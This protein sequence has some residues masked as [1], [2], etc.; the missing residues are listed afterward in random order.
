MCKSVEFLIKILRIVIL[1]NQNFHHLSCLL[2]LSLYFRYIAKAQKT[3]PSKIRRKKNKRG[4][5]EGGCVLYGFES[6]ANCQ[7]VRLFQNCVQKGVCN[8]GHDSGPCSIDT[9][10]MSQNRLKKENTIPI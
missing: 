10:H 3:V 7:L 1:Q 5:G 6:H 2:P 8:L 9:Q 4:D